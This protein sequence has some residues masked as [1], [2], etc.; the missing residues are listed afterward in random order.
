MQK[1]VEYSYQRN[2]AHMNTYCDGHIEVV[3]AGCTMA[4]FFCL[5]KHTTNLSIAAA[6]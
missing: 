2:Q 4:P 6:L 5:H 1:N 3:G